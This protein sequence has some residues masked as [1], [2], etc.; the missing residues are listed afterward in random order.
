MEKNKQFIE[1]YPWF[2][3]CVIQTFDD[4]KETCNKSLAGIHSVNILETLHKKNEQTTMWVFF[5]VNK[6][7]KWKR[8]KDS[9]LWVN[10]WIVECDDLSKAE[11]KKLIR[12]APIPPSAVVESDKSYHIYY[13]CEDWKIS[14]WVKIN[15]WLFQYFKWDIKVSK[16]IARVL[17]VPWFY[18]NKWKPYKC[19]CIRFEWTKHKTIDMEKAFPYVEEVVEYKPKPIKPFVWEATA[20]NIWIYLNS[21]DNEWMLLKL[22]WTSLVSWEII[23]VKQENKLRRIYINWKPISAWI[24]AHWLIWWGCN[25]WVGWVEWYKNLDYPEIRK[26]AIENLDIPKQYL[27]TKKPTKEV[28]IKKVKKELQEMQE[29]ASTNFILDSF[30]N[31]RAKNILTWGLEQVDYNYKKPQ[32]DDYVYLLWKPWAWKTTYSLFMAIENQ[33]RWAKVLYLSLEMNKQTLTDIYIET[34]WW[35]SE[36]QRE[37]LNYSDKQEE[38]IRRFANQLSLIDIYDIKDF[39]EISLTKI[40]ELAKGYDMVFVDNFWFIPTWEK[41]A[42]WQMEVSKTILNFVNSNQW[43]CFVMLHHFAKWQDWTQW[44]VG[45]GSQKLVDDA[46]RWITL[47]RTDEE[48]ALIFQ[49]NRSWWTLWKFKIELFEWKYREPFITI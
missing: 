1:N 36:Y 38:I 26:W 12:E 20:E 34:A 27:T 24:D 37:K 19:D 18:H 3:E 15:M 47:N 30:F 25:T 44:A 43:V 28:D 7:I 21:L 13:F 39:W 45:R 22:S 2:S 14:D 4:N 42:E 33:K 46:F 17:R 32:K 5:S 48:T 31:K 9:V 41:E 16:D 49:K 10:S 35:I 11:Q 8:N 29:S 23:T 40:L 6:M